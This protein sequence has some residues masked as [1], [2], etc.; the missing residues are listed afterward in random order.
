MITFEMLYSSYFVLILIAVCK[1]IDIR[2]YV[3]SFN[4]LEN[5]T[6]IEGSLQ[7]LLIDYAEHSRYKDLH[8]PKLLEITD[9]LLLYRVYGLKTLAHI[10][11]NLSVIR[12]QKLFFNYALVA[13]EMPNL[14][15]L[16][17]PSLTHIDR[18]A[19]RLE[20]NPNLCYINTIDWTK[21]ARRVSEEDHFISQNKDIDECVNVCPTD[22]EGKSLCHM[23]SIT[24]PSGEVRRQALCWTAKHCQKGKL[25]RSYVFFRH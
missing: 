3:I 14:E 6:V 7:I 17:L 9:Y 25:E 5:C 21:I 20:K 22:E 15:E 10:F 1:D 12:G 23:K 16:G 19:V 18:G 2:N 8:F 13:F 24:D 11:P 4:K